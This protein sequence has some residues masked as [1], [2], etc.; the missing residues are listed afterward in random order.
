M[1]DVIVI[2]SGMVGAACA[3]HLSEA[4]LRVHVVERG[5][6]VSGTSS[7]CE[8]NILFS[9]KASVP[10]LELQTL[11]TELWQRFAVQA[12]VDIELEHK[13]G[14]LVGNSDASIIALET[15]AAKQEAAGVRVDR[16]DRAGL[17]EHEPNLAAGFVG[18]LFYP[19][20]MQVMPVVAA[21]SMLRAARKRGATITPHTEVTGLDLTADGE[22][23]GITTRTGAVHA[24]TVVNCAGAWA[25]ELTA[26]WAAP[27]PVEPRR[28]YVLV[29]NPLPH[30]V[31]H[32]VYSAA[33]MDDVS[34]VDAALQSSLVVEGTKG[35]TVLIGASRERVGFDDQTRADI[36]Q[37]L[38]RQAIEVFPFLANASM[39]RFYQGFRPWAPGHL[40]IIGPDVH[41]PGLF[42][43]VGHEGEGIGLSQGTGR[44]ITEMVTGARLSMDARAFDPNRFVEGAQHA[45]SV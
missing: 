27:L 40:P 26:Q 36:V 5:M 17:Y 22:L 3:Y 16:L 9:S 21:Y 33:Y 14:V 35:G 4:G 41:V 29:T 7:R 8:G 39:L 24:P 32:K 42:H 10:E 6:P 1:N 28:G 38:A 37:R 25:G 2:G 19:D 30:V 34:S 44:L 20:D 12:D 23:R 45:A 11:S 18:G 31:N 43:A 15:Y 13:G